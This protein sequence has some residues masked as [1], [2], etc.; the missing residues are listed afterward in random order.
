MWYYLGSQELQGRWKQRGRRMLRGKEVTALP[1]EARGAW[2]IVGTLEWLKCVLS[3]WEG[4]Q[5]G[6]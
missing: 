6:G 5:G 4:H 1:A 2:E 3:A